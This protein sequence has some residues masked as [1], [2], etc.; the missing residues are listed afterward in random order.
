M[1]YDTINFI[2]AYWA[3]STVL[4]V[5]RL[6]FAWRSFKKYERE[7]PDFAEMIKHYKKAGKTWLAKMERH[8]KT[9][10]WLMCIPMGILLFISPPI[11]FPFTIIIGIV[12]VPYGIKKRRKKKEDEAL[13]ISYKL[14]DDAV[15]QMDS[16]FF[17]DEQFRNKFKEQDEYDAVINEH[18]H[19]GMFLR[20]GFALWDA[21]KSL[22]RFFIVNGITEAD[23][24]SSILLRAFHRKLNGIPFKAEEIIKEKFSKSN[25]GNNNDVPIEAIRTA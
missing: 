12:S 7:K 8:T 16:D 15:W 5:V 18:H 20:N 23:E 22:T 1:T 9:I 19:A 6:Y 3:L 11:F 13:K 21:T 25:S 17:K 2:I 14:F 24:M 10:I 4:S